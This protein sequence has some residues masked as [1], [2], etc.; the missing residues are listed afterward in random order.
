MM[1]APEDPRTR[2]FWAAVRGRTLEEMLQF[3]STGG[4]ARE[5]ELRD[6]LAQSLEQLPA[7]GENLDALLSRLLASHGID[8]VEFAAFILLGRLGEE[9]AAPLIRFERSFSSCLP[10]DSYI[11]PVFRTIQC[12]IAIKGGI[13]AQAELFLGQADS[14]LAAVTIPGLQELCRP[15]RV[16]N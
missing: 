16:A 9:D 12:N 14:A 13:P 10:A 15:L 6:S 8:W 7:T 3:A 11:W 1:G 2:L 5:E 4:G